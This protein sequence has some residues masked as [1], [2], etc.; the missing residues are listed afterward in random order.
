VWSGRR[1][2][3]SERRTRAGGREQRHRVRGRLPE[4]AELPLLRGAI[5]LLSVLD[6][7]LGHSSTLNLQYS[8]PRTALPP[9]R[10]HAHHTRN[11][12]AWP[13]YLQVLRSLV[14]LVSL[15]Q[16]CTLRQQQRKDEQ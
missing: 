11:T 15:V 16:Q 5:A 10:E 7:K 8:T 6:A 14:E 2:R 4:A 1:H 12:L 3:R 13:T 9:E